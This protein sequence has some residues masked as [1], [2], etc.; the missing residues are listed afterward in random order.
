MHNFKIAGV[1]RILLVLIALSFPAASAQTLQ[2]AAK[3]GDLAAVQKHIDDGADLDL[4]SG[5]GTALHWA[6]LNRHPDI[7]TLL[8]KSGADV[9]IATDAL[10]TPLHAAARFGYVAPAA[11]LLAHGVE[12][13]SRNRDTATPL[14]L[15][16]QAGKAAVVKLL[17]EHGADVNAQGAGPKGEVFG[18]PAGGLFNPLH[19]ASYE[20]HIEVADLLRAAGAG[21]QMDEPMGVSIA[22]A[23]PSRGRDIMYRKCVE[24]HQFEADQAPPKGFVQGPSL[25]GVVNRPIAS[26][27]DFAYTPAFERQSGSWSEAALFAFIS[28]PM[29]SI[30]GTRMRWGQID[31][32][33]DR[34]DIIAFLRGQSE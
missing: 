13:D 27:S 33:Q 9:D 29:L 7:I 30:P 28:H 17:I 14:H 24:C 25:V 19:L 18:I 34:A 6:V 12:V 4:L 15:A 10:G 26:L 21:P 16:A 8:A 22:D 5:L 11:T 2:D 3:S 31:A 23:N 20:G 1:S 32:P